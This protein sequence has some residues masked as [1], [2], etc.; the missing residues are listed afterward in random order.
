[1][2][3]SDWSSDVCS[4]DRH[5]TVNS[6]HSRKPAAACCTP[7]GLPVEPEVYKMNKGCS[8]FSGTASQTG[9]WLAQTSCIHRSRPSFHCTLPPVRLYTMTWLTT[10]QPPMVRASSTALLSGMALPPR[11]C[12]SAV[13]TSVAPTSTVRSC[14]FLD[15]KPPKTTA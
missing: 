5:L 4:S 8:A 15:E 6:D 3:I 9:D 14:R 13:M 10:S 11:T 2:L 7:L 12:S 1:M